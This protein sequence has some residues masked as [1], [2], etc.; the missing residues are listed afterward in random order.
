MIRLRSDYDVS[1]ELLPFDVI[2]REQKMNMS[3]FRRSRVVVLSL[4]KRT[5]IVISITFVV[6][7]C[8]VVSSYRSRM[9]IVIQ[10]LHYTVNAKQMAGNAER[11][12]VMF[13][14][15][16]KQHC[17]RSTKRLCAGRLCVYIADHCLRKKHAVKHF[18]VIAGEDR[19]S[20]ARKS[21]S[22]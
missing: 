22:L 12:L 13:L 9:A 15:S 2:R 5:Q 6:V 18:M 10:A 19:L 3:V 14:T 7:E 17:L 8:V 11:D 21:C 16:P 20:S 4:S 1:C